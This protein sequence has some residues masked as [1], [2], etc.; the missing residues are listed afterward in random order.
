MD[1][2]FVI[3]EI[4]VLS[5]VILATCYK[6][7]LLVELV[8]TLKVRVKDCHLLEVGVKDC[9]LVCLLTVPT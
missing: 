4:I 2:L 3:E 1:R 6:E 9:R 8:R 7:V 5:H